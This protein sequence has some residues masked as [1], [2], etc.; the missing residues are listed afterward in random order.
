M[1]A[2]PADLWYNRA[3]NVRMRRGQAMLEYVL[4][5]VSLLVVIG[6]LWGLVHAA[7]RHGERTES[8]VTSDCP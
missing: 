4:C 1:N 5:L 3:M 6:L 8:L 7:V 2:S